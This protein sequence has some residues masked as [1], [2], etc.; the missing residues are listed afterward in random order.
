MPGGLYARLCPAF[1]KFANF[2]HAVAAGHVVR[3]RV[4]WAFGVSE[5][6]RP[7]QPRRAH[8]DST[9]ESAARGSGVDDEAISSSRKSNDQLLHV[10]SK[11]QTEIA[12]VNKK[13]AETAARNE[14][15]ENEAAR[16]RCSVDLLST[17]V[18]RISKRIGDTSTKAEAKAT[19]SAGDGS[20]EGTESSCQPTIEQRICELELKAQQSETR[21]R[22][23][24]SALDAKSRK[25][26]N[27]EQ[28]LERHVRRNSLEV[29]NLCPREDDTASDVFLAFANSVL[30]VAVD[31][32]DIDSVCVVTRSS[33]EDGAANTKTV[34]PAEKKH[35]PRP[36]LITFT[37]YR[38]RTQV[39]QVH[40]HFSRYLS[41]GY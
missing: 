15:L 30:G 34:S 2:C 9:G 32:S 24:S 13:C 29:K 35:R 23:L 40:V 18:A 38:T 16:L 25:L 14:E 3:Q 7:S 27:V 5:K 12:E 37:C 8:V 22:K 20:A 17:S 10:V 28:D 33:N 21:L 19:P 4:L 1:L 41:V 26:D 39:Y 11:V 31:E 6:R 36:M